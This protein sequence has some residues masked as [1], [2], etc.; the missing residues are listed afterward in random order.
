MRGT[1]ILTAAILLA[2]LTV[3]PAVAADAAWPDCAQT[4][5]HNFRQNTD[6]LPTKPL[7]Q[8]QGALSEEGFW[9]DVPA[10]R[11]IPNDLAPSSAGADP[12]G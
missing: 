3:Q 1:S 7:R 4:S 8:S 12:E 10:N 9:Y 5:R 6:A 11:Q 2:S